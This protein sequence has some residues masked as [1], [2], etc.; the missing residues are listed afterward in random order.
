VEN[1]RARV[2]LAQAELES[3]REQLACVQVGVCAR[4]CVCW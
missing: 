1:E 3:A 2:Q 4:A